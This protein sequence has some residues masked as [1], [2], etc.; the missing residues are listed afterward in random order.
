MAEAKTIVYKKVGSLEIPFDLY[1]PKNAKK[2]PILLWFHGGGLLLGGRDLLAPHMRNGVNTHGYAC[3]SA[4]YRL[5]PQ[6]SVSE[7]FDDVKDCINFIRTELPSHVPEGALDVSRLAVSG[8]SAG[9]FLTLL[10]GLY[11]EP[12]PQVILPIYPI[13]DPLGVFFINT[14][15]APPGRYTASTEEMAP[16]LDTKAQPVSYTGKADVDPRAHMYVYMLKA[17]NLAELWHVPDAKS[18]LPYR[19]SRNIQKHGLPP[20]YVLHGD[21]DTA[22]GV[23]Q[24]DEVVGAMLGNG[25]TVEYE[26]PHGK[27][28]FLDMAEDYQNE[29][30]YAFLNKYL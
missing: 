11:I 15:P 23:E 10:A 7:I 30:F 28:H 9:G 14:Q 12:K 18:A 19:I 17:A 16:Y 5:A 29:A 27:D 20:S 13:T 3:I 22:V 26:R 24:S 1:L 4:D 21:A 6:V 8:S 2:A 25:L